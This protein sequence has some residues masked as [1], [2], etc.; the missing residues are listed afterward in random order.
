MTKFFA[1]MR[2]PS[3]SNVSGPVKRP[4]PKMTSTPRPRKRSGLSVGS[5]PRMTPAT[6]SI[7]SRELDLRR[8]AGVTAQRSAWRIW[9]AMRADLSQRLGGHT[10]VPEAIAAELVLLDDGH[11]GAERGPSGGDDESAGAAADHHDVEIRSHPCSPD[12]RAPASA[13][14]SGWS[15]SAA[16]AYSIRGR[17]AVKSLDPAIG[18]TGARLMIL[19]PAARLR[20]LSERQ[21]PS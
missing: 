9:Y 20:P 13:A 19:T 8:D 14:V 4:C 18:Y 7:T 10:A 17:V 21:V 2:R 1:V 15:R 6:R 12:R 5:M 3:T 11:L 16:A